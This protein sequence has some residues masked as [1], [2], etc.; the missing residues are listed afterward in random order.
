MKRF[1]DRSLEPSRWASDLALVCDAIG[2][3]AVRLAFATTLVLGSL[4]T[5]EAARRLDVIA[6]WLP[7]LP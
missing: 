4:A 2:L 7:L 3:L 6:P 5:H 1:A